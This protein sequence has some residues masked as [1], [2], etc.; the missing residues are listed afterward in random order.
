[1]TESTGMS[2]RLPVL[3]SQLND[4]HVAAHV[5]WK[6]CPKVDGVLALKPPTA[7]YPTGVLADPTEGSSAM[8]RTGRLGST[9]LAPVTSTQVAWA[10]T[11]VPRLNPICTLPSLVPAIATLMYF[12]E[13]LT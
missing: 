13:Y 9:A 6:T 7:A 12:G 11:P 5:T 10:A 2:G 8:P 1:M 4:A 3:S